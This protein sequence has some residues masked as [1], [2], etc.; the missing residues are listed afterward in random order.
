MS[1]G[2]NLTTYGWESATKA[3]YNNIISTTKI[4][5]CE[6]T[7]GKHE[8]CTEIWPTVVVSYSIDSE[9]DG[10]YK[11]NIDT[12]TWTLFSH[13]CQD[14]AKK[15]PRSLLAMDS[16]H[17]Q[18]YMFQPQW[19]IKS[20]D[21]ARLHVLNIHKQKI[22]RTFETQL[23][24]GTNP[25]CLCVNGSLHVISGCRNTTHFEWNI[26][27]N[28][29]TAI[30][31][32]THWYNLQCTGFV[33]IASQNILLSFGGYYNSDVICKTS[34]D[35]IHWEKMDIKLPVPMAQNGIVVTSDER[36]ILFF[37][38]G[39]ND[40]DHRKK[41]FNT[42]YI[43][44]LQTWT[45]MKS[46]YTMPCDFT[47]SG[48]CAQLMCNVQ[49]NKLLIPGYIRSTCPWFVP[50]DVIHELKAWCLCSEIH[51]FEYDTGLHWRINTND[52]LSMQIYL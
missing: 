22:I 16:I 37:G 18:V 17:N 47:K 48:S 13:D 15:C 45:F 28:T 11:Y 7:A 20:Y 51:L 8:E 21:K 46:W 44:N 5:E 31:D 29:F 23:Q 14:E 26:N 34:L 42:I 49:Q 3:P 33:H 32:N 38:N 10:I 2:A 19:N 35:V 52:L 12:N 39:F 9:H 24:L 30:A 41:G 50:N 1:T 4:N 43:L 27:T 36:F 40:F 6:F 25:S